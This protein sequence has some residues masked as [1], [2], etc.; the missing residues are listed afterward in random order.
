MKKTKRIVLAAAVFTAL[1]VVILPA[2][3]SDATG[4]NRNS[5]GENLSTRFSPVNSQYPGMVVRTG[6][7]LGFTLSATDPDND[8]L[9][10][11]A[12]NLPPGATFDPLTGTFS[13]TP[14]FDQAGVYPSIHFE[15]SDGELTDSEDITITVINFDRPPV[16]NAISNQ[17]TSEKTPLQFTVSAADPDNDNLTYSASNLPPGASFSPQTRTFSWTP[18]SGQQGTYSGVR[19]T[20][21]DGTLTDSQAVTITVS[22]AINT[23]GAAT[24][25]FSVSALNISPPKVNAGKNVNIRVTAT[26]SGTADGTYDVMLTIDGTVEATQSVA[27]PAG[28]SVT[29]SFAVVRDIAGDYA[30]D[31][32]GLTGTFQVTGSSGGGGGKSSNGKNPPGKA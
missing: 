17:S 7:L 19:F 1:L 26:N 16:L 4:P 14:G 2:T 10:Y 15:V 27:I 24:A 32:N 5:P 6:A 3:A 23:T 12:S 25:V 11:S 13:W 18:N 29:V 28:S 8:L 22:S 21:S 31:V 20:V 9:T 30:V